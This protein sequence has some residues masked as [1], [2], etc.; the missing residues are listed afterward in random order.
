VQINNFLGM[1]EEINVDTYN[2]QDEHDAI[3]KQKELN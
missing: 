2:L 3:K 1:C